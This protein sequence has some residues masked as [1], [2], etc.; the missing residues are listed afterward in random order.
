MDELRDKI[1]GKIRDIIYQDIDDIYERK[2][3]EMTFC[4][5]KANEIIALFPQ[6]I[7]VENPPEIHGRAY[8]VHSRFGEH[9]AWFINNTFFLRSN[10]T[11]IED[12]THW[13][14]LPAPPKKG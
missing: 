1:R 14:P 4:I 11:P 8:W 13:M 2:T 7:S 10:M 12:V 9:E 5:I 6:W 3:D